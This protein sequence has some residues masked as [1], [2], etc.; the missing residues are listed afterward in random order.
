MAWLRKH[1]A[2]CLVATTMHGAGCCEHMHVMV[3]VLQFHRAADV[4]H[5]HVERHS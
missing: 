1:G 5:Q 4:M 3:S 2:L